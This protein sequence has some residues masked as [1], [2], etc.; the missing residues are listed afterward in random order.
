MYEVSKYTSVAVT[1]LFE[2]RGAIVH[3]GHSL[4]DLSNPAQQLFSLR[5]RDFARTRERAQLG[6]WFAAAFDHN[7][8]AFLG[9]TDEF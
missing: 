4:P 5:G 8:A 7:D 1:I 6:D 3:F 2:K 9:L